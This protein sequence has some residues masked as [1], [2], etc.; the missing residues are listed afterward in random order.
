MVWDF[1]QDVSI[2]DDLIPLF[3]F[4]RAE[5][6]QFRPPD[7]FVASAGR[8]AEAIGESQ[9][10]ANENDRIAAEKLSDVI[11]QM[12]DSRATGQF[13]LVDIQFAEQVFGKIVS[14]K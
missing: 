6:S 1:A 10:L 5:S 14:Q 9:V 4:Q 8:V 13:R 3:H 2:A 7:V 12:R 11:R